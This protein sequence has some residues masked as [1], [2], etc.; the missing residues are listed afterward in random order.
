MDA[1]MITP[2]VSSIQNVL[3]TMLQLNVTVGDPAVKTDPQPTHDV[4]GIIGM[5]GEVVGSVAQSYPEETADALVASFVGETLPPSSP[6]FADAI[7]ELANMVS[8][9]AKALFPA[10]RAVNISVP[11]VVIG[12]G[13]TVAR[14]SDIPCV[15]VPCE[16]DCG[17]FVI[18][19]GLREQPA[20]QTQTATQAAGA[21]G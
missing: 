8:G 18:E 14:R 5:S 12:S 10:G 7:G 20:E 1:S 21:Q 13:H 17:S 9:G 15:I 3:S 6:D 19:I 11:S 4:S 2:F 16:T